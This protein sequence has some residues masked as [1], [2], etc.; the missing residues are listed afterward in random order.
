MRYCKSDVACSEKAAEQMT[1]NSFLVPRKT[2]LSKYGPHM[3]VHIVQEGEPGEEFFATLAR[4]QAIHE[5]C[6]ELL[7]T[8]HQR[9]GLELMDAMAVYQETGYERLSR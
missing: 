8:Q 6:K 9:A 4:V 7:R 3:Q 1:T 5:N 2:K